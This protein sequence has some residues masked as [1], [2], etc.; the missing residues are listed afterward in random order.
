MQL[1]LYYKN[2]S[3][4]T[5]DQHHRKNIIIY[6]RNFF[7]HRIKFQYRIL[8]IHGK[9]DKKIQQGKRMYRFLPLSYWKYARPRRPRHSAFK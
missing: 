9:I 3:L 7:Q 6:T 1:P 2:I 5:E 4:K 8:T